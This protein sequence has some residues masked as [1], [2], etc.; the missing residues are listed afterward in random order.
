MKIY[1]KTGDDGTTG[2]LGGVRVRK[3]DPRVEAYGEV[4]ELNSALAVVRAAGV[5]P[6]I[7][8][9]LG[10]IQHELFDIGAELATPPNREAKL[11]APRVS[12]PQIANL[13]QAI[14]RLEQELEPLA[15][16]ILPG[17]SL[18]SA[19][20]HLARSIGRRAE[21]RVIALSSDPNVRQ[22]V[23]PEVV[24]YLNRLSDLLFVIARTVNARANIADVPW[25]GRKRNP[26]P[27]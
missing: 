3:S 17:G 24:Q 16:F 25:M 8:S 11:S 1:T 9:L 4:D 13:E 22:E 2:L 26:P 10:D 12:N 23:R 7:D 5:A 20:L 27:S 14:D 18:A 21:R 15:N 19:H 6:D